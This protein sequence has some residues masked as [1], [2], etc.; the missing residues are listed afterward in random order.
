MEVWNIEW[1]QF[2]REAII[3]WKNNLWKNDE[4][5]IN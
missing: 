1:S 3:T 2:L 4:E 5:N